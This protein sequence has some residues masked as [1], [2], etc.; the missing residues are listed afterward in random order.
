[1]N[2]WFSYF[3]WIITLSCAIL[4]LLPVKLQEKLILL[5]GS[6]YKEC[7]P[8]FIPSTVQL[9]NRTC[10][11][12]S[13]HMAYTELRDIRD[14]DVDNINYNKNKLTFYYGLEDRWCPKAYYYNIKDKCPGVNAILCDKGYQHAFVLKESYQVAQM[15]VKWIKRLH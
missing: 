12:S 7:L 1:M 4:S 10:V 5:F 11:G 9:F 3:W 6:E 14:L 13:L 15:I 2:P 8:S